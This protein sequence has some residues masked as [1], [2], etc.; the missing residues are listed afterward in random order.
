M[1]CV[2]ESGVRDGGMG[3]YVKGA[4]DVEWRGRAGAQ[5]VAAKDLFSIF[6]RGT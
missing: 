3:W 4:T 5:I 1:R 2:E 6:V